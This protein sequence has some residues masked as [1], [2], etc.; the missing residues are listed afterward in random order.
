MFFVFFTIMENSTSFG[1]DKNWKQP[2]C[3]S[4]GEWISKLSYVQKWKRLQLV[5]KMDEGRDSAG[6]PV[7]KNPPSN[8]GMQV[9]SL[10]RERRSP[11]TH[12]N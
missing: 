10:V 3:S 7:V 8:A 5:Q 11:K 2:S 4:T 9:Q 12:S 6:G 1:V